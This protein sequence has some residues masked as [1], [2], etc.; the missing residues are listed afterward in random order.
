[1]RCDLPL[2]PVVPIY[3]AAEQEEL[4][5]S[6]GRI[7]LLAE[8]VGPCQ[9]ARQDA[10]V[11]IREFREPA[12]I[13]VLRFVTEDAAQPSALFIALPAALQMRESLFEVG[14][15]STALLKRRLQGAR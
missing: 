3:W 2:E 4:A 6:S 15:V 11:V 5:K 13:P 1:M 7:V 12:E 14:T 10:P 9:P 8:K